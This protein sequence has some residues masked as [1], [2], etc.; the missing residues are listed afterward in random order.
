MLCP[1]PM[2]MPMIAF[3]SQDQSGDAHA[4]G[5]TSTISICGSQMF[6]FAGKPWP[7]GQPSVGMVVCEPCSAA[8]YGQ[9]G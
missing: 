7:L 1:M 8:V 4:V 9:P 3:A 2:P 6:S 5:I